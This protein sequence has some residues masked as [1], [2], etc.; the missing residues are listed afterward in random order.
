M[1]FSEAIA[2]CLTGV[3]VLIYVPVIANAFRQIQRGEVILTS[4]TPLNPLPKRYTGASAT[5]YA[6]AQALSAVV[7]I[8][9][10]MTAFSTGNLGWIVFGVIAS[11]LV[12]WG[13]LK[14]A[15][16]LGYEEIHPDFEGAMNVFSQFLS[17]ATG[18][19]GFTVTNVQVAYAD[20]DEDND[21]DDDDGTIIIDADADKGHATISG[22]DDGIEDADFRPIDRSDASNRTETDDPSEK[23][24]T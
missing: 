10:A 12:G 3:C 7:I 24:R 14:W 13:G 11:M 4:V 6:L 18:G 23:P 16:Q 22:P 5:V 21:N 8:A 20:D 19:M 1:S 2:F 17:N 9:G 15:D